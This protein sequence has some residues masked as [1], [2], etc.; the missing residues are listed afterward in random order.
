[1][2]VIIKCYGMKTKLKIQKC[3]IFLIKKIEW[4]IGRLKEGIKF[5]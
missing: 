3:A 1:M 5:V 2:L 4:F